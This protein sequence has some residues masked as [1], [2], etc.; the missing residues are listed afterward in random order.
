MTTQLEL[1]QENKGWKSVMKS[2]QIIFKDRFPEEDVT[3][4]SQHYNQIN[5]GRTLRNS[6]LI[7]ADQ[8]IAFVAE[9]KKD[10]AN[11]VFIEDKGE[12][13]IMLHLSDLQFE[14][15]EGDLL[16]YFQENSGIFELVEETNL[17]VYNEKKEEF[18]AN[19]GSE[20]AN[21]TSVGSR[22]T[23]IISHETKDILVFWLHHL[24][25][26]SNEIYNHL[27][28][29]MLQFQ[30]MPD[31]TNNGYYTARTNR[32]GFVVRLDYGRDI[33]TDYY[34]FGQEHP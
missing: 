31:S 4:L 32:I 26:H 33:K 6:F 24:Y 13:S 22:N 2:L 25:E 27:E 18:R 3:A 19:L 29:K 16:Y 1:L 34:N 10:Y 28:I 20:I 11:F 21:A 8:F 23:E 7:N 30:S 17:D 14:K 9:A 12:L 5:I 15:E